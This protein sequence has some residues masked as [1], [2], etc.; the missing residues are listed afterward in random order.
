MKVLMVNK[1]LH[2]AGGAE[3]YLFQLGDYLS[4]QG[5]TVQYFGMEHP[6]RKVG[7]ALELYTAN[8]D[9]HGGSLWKKLGYPFRIIS[10]REAR[11]K[12]KAVLEDFQPD[13]IHLNNFNYQLT[14]SILL[15]AR[16]YRKRHT[17]KLLYTAHDVQLVCPN[18]LMYR[19]DLRAVCQKCQEKG[20]WQCV[21]GKC[22]HGSRM[23]S[24]LGALEHWYW[25]KR[26]VYRLLDTIICPSAFMKTRLDLDPV[27]AERT[28]VLRNFVKKNPVASQEKGDYVLYFGRYSEEKGLRA[29]LEVC[30]GLTDIPFVFA[31]GGPLEE[32]V[33][34]TENVKNLGFLSG[35]RLQ[36][37]I[38]GARFSVCPSECNENCPFSV[39]E[40]IMAGTPVLGSDRGGIPELI[41]NG[42]TGWLFPAANREALSDAI[43]RLYDSREPERC[44]ENCRQVQFD[45]LG[46]YME[47]LMKYYS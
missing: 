23:R 45:D 25:K 13:V 15:A 20:P 5:H 7:N 37:V 12:M 27:L 44:S 21:R 40:S 11:R 31:G 17:V 2:P 36:E 16:D 3:T 19:A 24:L 8:M 42:K 32:L 38:A 18:H 33:N 39:M 14:P 41:D 43:R 9:F 6:D 34:A 47:K 29:L 30:G 10:S 28:V 1:F 35:Q 22:I 26:R 46:Q 4:R